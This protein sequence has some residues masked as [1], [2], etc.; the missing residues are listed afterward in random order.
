VLIA[1]LGLLLVTSSLVLAAA[2]RTRARLARADA[3]AA[4]VRAEAAAR[5]AVLAAIDSVSVLL[6]A[7]ASAGL[8]SD[9]W[10]NVDTLAGVE[11]TIT[12]ADLASKLHINTATAG[13]LRQF[14]MAS[15]ISASEADVASQSIADWQDPDQLHHPRGAEA[16]WYRSAGFDYVPSDR[17]IA[18]YT[19][20]GA[21]RG[22][23]ASVLAALE[24]SSSLHGDGRTNMNSAP[25]AVLASLPGVSPPAAAA[26]AA[27]R[28]ERYL[29]N[30][31]EIIEAVPDPWRHDL[32]MALPEIA[33][34]LTFE[35][36]DLE[37]RTRA[38]VGRAAFG[39]V[40]TA[41]H[42]GNGR[43][44]ITRTWYAK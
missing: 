42:T 19:E 22:S 35:L 29:T 1:M 38:V 32:E 28:T 14:L 8:P 34:R 24:S 26:I 44:V 2:L 18:S 6:R 12:T 36:R 11:V 27:R 4:S 16:E 33:P 3:F 13:E 9:E 41:H 31:A 10:I 39:I 40:A 25:I 20:L 15:G 43:F 5:F 7:S 37:I 17:P 21:V 23:T 30:L